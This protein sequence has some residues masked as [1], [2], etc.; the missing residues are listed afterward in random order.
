MRLIKTTLGEKRPKC[1]AGVL[2]GRF[3]PVG[4]LAG[5][6]GCW[7]LAT[8]MFAVDPFFVPSPID[9]ADAFFAAPGYLLQETAAT[10][11]ITL[12][13]FGLATASGLIVAALIATSRTVERAVMPILVALHSVPKVSVAPLLV[14]WLG[15]GAQPKIA[16]VMVISFFPIM[17][18]AAAGLTSTPRELAELAHSLS[19]SRWQKFVKIRFPW[20]LP[21]FLVGLKAGVTLAVI[22]AVVAE[23]ASSNSGLGT[24]ILTAGTTADTPTAFAAIS[25]L[26]LMSTSLFFGLVAIERSMLAWASET[27]A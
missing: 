9:V 23:L 11:G 14:V 21:Q 17:L 15:F 4:A 3:L 25:L 6:V 26:A 8:A 2:L 13:G 1:S 20:A 24:V 19:A 7:W 5:M 10:A 16:M 22:G 27:T 12:A 18:A